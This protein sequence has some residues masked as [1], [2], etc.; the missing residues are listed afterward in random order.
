MLGAV[1]TFGDTNVKRKHGAYDVI[2]TL[3]VLVQW[4]LS[5]HV[6]LTSC[7]QR[8][9]YTFMSPKVPIVMRLCI[10]GHD[11]NTY[12]IKQSNIP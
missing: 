4:A 1:E 2:L 3:L 6:K 12:T 8:L 7:I 11:I 5:N 9:R 10:F